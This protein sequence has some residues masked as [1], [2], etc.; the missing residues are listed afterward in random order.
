MAACECSI[1]SM[2]AEKLPNAP[3]LVDNLPQGLVLT[4]GDK[5]VSVTF[6]PGY[7]TISY[8]CGNFDGYSYC[9][10]INLTEVLVYDSFT[11]KEVQL[12]YG[13]FSFF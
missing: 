1:T 4:V 5:P 3:T 8:N 11:E 7:D 6:Q 9:D 10:S 2:A 13:I 12:P